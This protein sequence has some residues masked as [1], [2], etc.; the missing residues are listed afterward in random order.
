MNH[1]TES[2]VSFKVDGSHEDKQREAD[3]SH[4]QKGS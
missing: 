3:G 1:G 4:E 2:A